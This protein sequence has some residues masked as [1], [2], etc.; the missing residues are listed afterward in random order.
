MFVRTYSAHVA[1]ARC[2][3][4][5]GAAPAESCAPNAAPVPTTTAHHATVTS[6]MRSA[7]SGVSRRYSLAT[8]NEAATIAATRLD[9]QRRLPR[10]GDQQ[11]RSGKAD[12]QTAGRTR[13][14]QH[15]RRKSQRDLRVVH[16]RSAD[17]RERGRKQHD[18]SGIRV[19]FGERAAEPNSANGHYRVGQVSGSNGGAIRGAERVKQPR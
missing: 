16:E 14:E 7:A 13:V 6:A 10:Q 9:L 15:Q 4:K 8:A 17:Q 3:S 5:C 11:Q 18:E 2:G 19:L 1:C 12:P